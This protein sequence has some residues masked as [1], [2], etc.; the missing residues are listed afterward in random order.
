MSK[1]RDF[2]AK[3]QTTTEIEPTA[4]AREVLSSF[5]GGQSCSKINLHSAHP[6][7]PRA[8]PSYSLNPSCSISHAAFVSLSLSLTLFSVFPPIRFFSP[9]TWTESIHRRGQRANRL[10]CNFVRIDVEPRATCTEKKLSDGRGEEKS[11]AE[12]RDCGDGK[13][14]AICRR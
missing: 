4:I 14:I 10:R 9:L 13:E 11:Y 5:R 8:V 1:S 6:I 7:I 2:I 12:R 3:T